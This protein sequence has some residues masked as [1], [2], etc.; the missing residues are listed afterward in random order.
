MRIDDLPIFRDIRDRLGEAN[1]LQSLGDLRTR[2]S[3]L[4]GAKT[5]S[6]RQHA[7]LEA[8]KRFSQTGRGIYDPPRP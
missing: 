4:E 8:E 2:L 6:M 3:D 5:A 1:C 7:I